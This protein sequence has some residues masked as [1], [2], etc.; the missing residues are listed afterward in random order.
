M[1]AGPGIGRGVLRLAGRPVLLWEAL[2]A[3]VAMRRHR[4]LLPSSDYI[5]WRVHTAYGDDMSETRHE[6]LASYLR[7]RRM[8]RAIR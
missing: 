4:G 5:T 3:G 6:D 1:R 7:W 8:M 2:R